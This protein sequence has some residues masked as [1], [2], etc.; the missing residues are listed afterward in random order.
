MLRALSRSRGW[1]GLYGVFIWNEE[2]R[3]PLFAQRASGSPSVP[4][5]WDYHVVALAPGEAVWDLDC[6]A[7][8]PVAPEAWLAASLPLGDRA[9]GSAPVL[10]RAVPARELS[11]SFQSDRSHMR[12]P[13]G[14]W[15]A[16]PPPW[17]PLSAAGS[18][19]LRFVST[20][21]GWMGRVMRFEAFSRFAAGG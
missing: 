20:D 19:L 1:T 17:P 12:R 11:D 14:S 13:D 8:C 10:F 5:F 6:L 4:A 21:P 15:S 7:G 3:L 9:L 18:N 16:P 2:R